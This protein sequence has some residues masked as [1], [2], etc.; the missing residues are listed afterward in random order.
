MSELASLT[1]QE[2]V[3]SSQYLAEK[4]GA[5][6]ESFYAAVNDLLETH[7]LTQVRGCET[8][9]EYLQVTI[10][11]DPK[12]P[13]EKNIK[14]ALINERHHLHCPACRERLP[15]TMQPKGETRRGY[16]WRIESPVPLPDGLGAYL[17]VSSINCKRCP[18]KARFIDIQV[19][20][21][22]TLHGKRPTD[23][24]SPCLTSSDLHLQVS[25]R[26]R[27]YLIE[28]TGRL[29]FSAR[30]ARASMNG[31][32]QHKYPWC[33]IGLMGLS[34]VRVLDATQDYFRV[35]PGAKLHLKAKKE[36]NSLH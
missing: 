7:H 36:F 30:V 33:S 11:P 26:T 18:E 29:K 25:D 34:D 1:M 28:G 14:G 16:V 10:G 22:A 35:R 4:L 27:A 9:E 32:V 23:P 3:D 6:Q 31:Y 21:N 19:N 13:L 17:C 8:E 20:A 15:R 12:T 24:S 2:L 5:N